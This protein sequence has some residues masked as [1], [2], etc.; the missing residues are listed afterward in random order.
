M[1]DAGV[2]TITVGCDAATSKKAI[3]FAN[4][5][6]NIW[7]TV[8]QHP[9]DNRAEEFDVA[10]YRHMAEDPKVVA[11][12]ECGLDYTRLGSDPEKEKARQKELFRAQ[13]ALAQEVG[14]PLMIHAR[15]SGKDQ[16]QNADAH[17][18]ILEILKAFPDM[19]I[20]LHF[21][22]GSPEVARRYT[23]EHDAYFSFSGV[24][25]FAP[26][27]ETTVRAVPL[28]R[29][30]VETDAPYAAPAPHRGERNEPVF[31]IDTLK[32]VAKLRG[33]N[34]EEMSVQILKNS[35]EAFKIDLA[36]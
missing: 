15:S 7:A 6:E 36:A 19:R 27:Y 18:D 2:G 28:E 35:K 13:A 26:M 34:E 21:F 3:E 23:A 24:V 29:I 17:D 8:G 5:H 32:Y 33:K 30:L 22:T 20:V 16:E 11:I 1:K 12:G 4:A 10:I 31:V 25:T 14:K 9:A